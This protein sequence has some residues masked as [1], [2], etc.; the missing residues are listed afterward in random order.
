MTKAKLDPEA[1]R[2]FRE[3]GAEGGKK[4]AARLTPEERKERA[5]GATK[6][7]TPEERSRRARRAVNA[8]WAKRAAGVHKPTVQ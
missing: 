2:F 8:R 3:A 7:L 6:T 4:A 1:L 5:R